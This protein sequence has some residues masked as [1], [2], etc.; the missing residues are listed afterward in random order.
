MTINKLSLLALGAC[1]LTSGQLTHAAYARLA[2]QVG[3]SARMA[4]AAA[5]RG[6]QAV[7]VS[8]Q[9]QWAS[10]HKGALVGAGLATGAIFST[11][12]AFEAFEYNEMSES[13]VRKLLELKTS[14][15][16]SVEKDDLESDISPYEPFD[17]IQFKRPTHVDWALDKIFLEEK[18]KNIFSREQEEAEFEVSPYEPFDLIQHKGPKI[19]PFVFDENVVDIPEEKKEEIKAFFK[20]HGFHK[21]ELRSYSPDTLAPNMAV[22]RDVDTVFLII[23][24]PAQRAW[25]RTNGLL[26]T[27]VRVLERIG[28]IPYYSADIL[29][30]Q[31]DQVL[32]HEAGHIIYNHGYEKA[33]LQCR[34]FLITA[35]ISYLIGGGL[36]FKSLLGAAVLQIPSE[37]ISLWFSRRCER[38]ADQFLIE[39]TDSEGIKHF[40]NF[41]NE[42]KCIEK[43]I[44]GGIQRD[45]E[46]LWAATHPSHDERIGYLTKALEERRK[47]EQ[48]KV[49][50]PE[51]EEPRIDF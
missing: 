40:I 29:P 11:Q 4:L 2:T 20:K 48:P 50:Q 28:S 9:V 30:E 41:F 16:N 5:A 46:K 34:L 27:V 22:Y 25:S 7:K 1:F 49:E 35:G 39:N 19:K 33:V 26:R 36:G 10:N 43:R 51:T 21:V 15:D 12:K 24:V 23:N 42:L 32:Y 8:K 44:D 38:E 18:I 17:L 45:E 14:L 47:T 37:W 13:E 6:A 31:L 3:T